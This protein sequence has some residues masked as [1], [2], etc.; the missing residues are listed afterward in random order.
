MRARFKPVRDIRGRVPTAS[1]VGS[2][3]EARSSAASREQKIR[4]HPARRKKIHWP[5]I[6]VFACPR[7]AMGDLYRTAAIVALPY[8]PAR[9]D[10]ALLGH[11]ARREGR[12]DKDRRP[13]AAAVFV[14]VHA[15]PH[16]SPW[17]GIVCP[18]SGNW[19]HRNRRPLSAGAMLHPRRRRFL[20]SGS[21][22]VQDR[23]ISVSVR[24]C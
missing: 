17:N 24:H 6:A 12:A 16:R 8:C 15:Q 20:Q 4:S 22:T 21:V 19:V 18:A 13:C 3:Y 1:K 11:V 23:A 2:G 10:L 7:R 14:L 5:S 9:D